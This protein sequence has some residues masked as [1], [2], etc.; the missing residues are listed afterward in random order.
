MNIKM[1]Q[2]QTT[3]GKEIVE[4]GAAKYELNYHH[5]GEV[6]K[7]TIKD[8]TAEYPIDV[9][10]LA[11]ELMDMGWGQPEISVIKACVEYNYGNCMHYPENN[12]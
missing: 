7:D 4:G 12:I 2:A 11:D 5:Y 10:R 8:V 6:K 3:D 1:Y 9:D